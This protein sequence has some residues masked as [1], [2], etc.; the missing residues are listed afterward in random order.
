MCRMISR[1]GYRNTLHN[2]SSRFNL[3]AARSNRAACD[4]QGLV[5]CSITTLFIRISRNDCS[6]KMRAA[7]REKHPSAHKCSSIWA[8]KRRGKPEGG[9]GVT[10]DERYVDRGGTGVSSPPVKARSAAKE[11]RRRPALA[12]SAT[13]LDLHPL[14]RS[15]H[16]RVVVP[17]LHH[18]LVDHPIVMI[19]IVMEQN[20]FL[21]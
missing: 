8:S 6:C 21:C 19:R 14:S 12:R 3:C 15:P 2:P 13:N 9:Q 11:Q 16:S 20:Q 10:I 5:S 18:D 7:F 1:L 4:S 17:R